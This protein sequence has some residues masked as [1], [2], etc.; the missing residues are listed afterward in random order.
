MILSPNKWIGRGSWRVTTDS[1]GVK[2]GC[3]VHIVDEGNGT[4]IHVEVETETK[5]S[6]NYDVWIVPDETGLYTITVNN[7]GLALEGIGK[8]ESLPHLA[9]LRSV[10]AD[11]QLVLAVFEM[12]EV[13]GTRG[14][15]THQ[16]HMYTFEIALR[17]QVRVVQETN[18]TNE[19]VTIIPFNPRGRSS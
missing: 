2:F 14:F 13:F 11:T 7:S 6:M 1:T 9:T 8:L 18:E 17:R 3:H 5:N 19:N 12:P 15:Y 4:S 16:Q 10:D